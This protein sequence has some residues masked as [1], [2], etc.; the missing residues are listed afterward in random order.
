M[1]DK[2]NLVISYSVPNNR[3]MPDL[4]V[5]VLGKEYVISNGKSLSVTIDRGEYNLFFKIPFMIKTA[6]TDYKIDLD[7]DRLLEIGWNS[8]WG[9]IRI[10]ETVTHV[11]L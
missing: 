4:H 10:K 5:T 1:Y 2:V 11:T 8:I 7:C 6:M 9:R 3:K